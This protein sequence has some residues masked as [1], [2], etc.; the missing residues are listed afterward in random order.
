MGKICQFGGETLHRV[1]YLLTDY[2]VGAKITRSTWNVPN[3]YWEVTRVKYNKR[4]VTEEGNL[5]PMGR[6]WGQLYW[7]GELRGTERQIPGNSKA[8]WI[9]ADS[10]TCAAP[11]VEAEAPA[12]VP[13][14]YYEPRKKWFVSEYARLPIPR[15][16][17]GYVWPAPSIRM[18]ERAPVDPAV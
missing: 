12:K 8:R 17:P 9:V 6:A 3:S 4:A 18:S 5:R 11:V 14:A 15:G 16:A 7:K 1:L 10:L 13:V 2:G